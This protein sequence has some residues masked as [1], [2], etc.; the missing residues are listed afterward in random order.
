M[1]GRRLAGLSAGAF[2]VAAATVVLGA[3]TALATVFTPG[4]NGHPT[5]GTLSD[6]GSTAPSP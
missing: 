2:T 6:I 5:D 3:G 4:D 1:T